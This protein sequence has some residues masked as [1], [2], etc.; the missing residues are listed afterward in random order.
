MNFGTTSLVLLLTTNFKSFETN[1]AR[2]SH[3]E[4]LHF[5]TS[6]K[7]IEPSTA[8]EAILNAR[9]PVENFAAIA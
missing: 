9:K 3:L 2:R 4:W 5:S 7:E 1:G 6:S 8:N